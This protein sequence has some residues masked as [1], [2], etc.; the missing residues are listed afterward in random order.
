[1]FRV[2]TVRHKRD[3]LAD[4]HRQYFFTALVDDGNLIEVDD[5][6]ASGPMVL[7]RL[8]IGDEFRDRISGQVT[9]K[10]P[11]L[12]SINLLDR[13]SQHWFVS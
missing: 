3:A 6:I 13:D 5:P 2:Q 1:V 4:H 10:D 11:L 7:G 8:P 12:S 9:L